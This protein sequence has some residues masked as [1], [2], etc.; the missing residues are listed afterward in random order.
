MAQESIG[1]LSV[2]CCPLPEST[3]FPSERIRTLRRQ[4]PCDGRLPDSPLWDF[5][6]LCW[7]RLII[8]SVL[9]CSDRMTIRIDLSLLLQYI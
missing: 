3:S 5:T 6:Y 9:H 1:V 8:L 4:N 2:R 7:V